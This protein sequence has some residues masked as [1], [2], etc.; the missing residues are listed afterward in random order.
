EVEL[1]IK[2]LE[3][4]REE[5]IREMGNIDFSTDD[6]SYLD[7]GARKRKEEISYHERR[8]NRAE[9]LLCFDQISNPPLPREIY[10]Q[11]V[12]EFISPTEMTMA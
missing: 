5:I 12:L 4:H 10:N 11:E 1:K 9:A 7:K 8:I 2:T 3:S 6:H